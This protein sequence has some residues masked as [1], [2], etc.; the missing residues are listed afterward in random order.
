MLLRLATQKGY[1]VGSFDNT[2][3]LA[4]REAWAVHHG[5]WPCDEIDHIQPKRAD[6]RLCN[7]GAQIDR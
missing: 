5:E 3:F 2:M 7:L 4:H 1:L 6:N